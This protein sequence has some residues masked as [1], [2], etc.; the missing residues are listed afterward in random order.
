VHAL[1]DSSEPHRAA[2]VRALSQFRDGVMRALPSLVQAF[3]KARP[4]VRPA[5]TVL[6][7]GIRPPIFTKEAIPALAAVLGSPEPDL[8]HAA[9]KALGAYRKKDAGAAVSAL[10]SAL[11]SPNPET[12]YVAATCLAEFG[13]D[14]WPVV[15]ALVASLERDDLALAAS[16]TSGA[17]HDPK[18]AAA[19]ALLQAAPE[20]YFNGPPL[21]GRSLAAL[22]RAL[23]SGRPDVRE[24]IAT[25]LG[26]M[27]PTPA[28]VPPLAEAVRDP[29]PA[30]RAAALKSLDQLG[31]K[32]PFAPPEAV[33]AALED[34]APKVRF[35]AAGTIGHAGREIDPFLPRLLWHAEH[36][37]DAD[38]RAACAEA[39]RDH[40]KGDAVTPAV[41][42]RLIEALG[43]PDPQVV[44][45][46]CG[47]L[48]RIGPAARS[49]IPRLRQ[50]EQHGPK[51]V[52]GAAQQAVAALE[53]ARGR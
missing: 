19:R 40:I 21:D 48:G 52:Q 17:P 29:L 32:V 23:R 35:W 30:V 44:T 31:R 42:P 18:L 25:V 20:R 2:A 24:T 11:G 9:A 37:P 14:V 50:C 49:A 41:V 12:R 16:P 27:V 6:I 8:R 22:A 34:E 38:V 5:Y 43:S 39:V 33:R 15:P 53:S 1:E 45:A 28:L 26:R 36:D 13:Q 4:E 46:A 47:L 10:G 7:E 3:G 51:E